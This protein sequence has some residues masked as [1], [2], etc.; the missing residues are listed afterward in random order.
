M[1]DGKKLFRQSSKY[2]LGQIVVMVA[3]FISFPVLT[4]IFTVDNYGTLGIVTT[5]IMLATAIAKVGSTNSS[6]RYFAEYKKNG[7]LQIYYSTMTF[8]YLSIAILVSLI[9]FVIGNMFNLYGNKN[10]ILILVISLLVILM[11]IYSVLQGMLRAEQKIKKYIVT[12]IIFRYGTITLG[13]LALFAIYKSIEIYLATQALVLLV[14]I[15]II[16]F[17]INKRYV[18]SPASFSIDLFKDSICYGFFL[19]ISE[20]AHLILTYADR[21]LIQYILGAA[22]LGVYTAGYNLST[23]VVE[24]LMY[25][26]NNAIDPIY[27]NIYSTRG[28]EDTQ[29]FLSKAFKYYFI[30]MAFAVLAFISVS[31][32]L[33]VILASSKYETA[34]KIMP[35]VVI[36]NAIYSL[37]VIINAGLI[38]NK[39]TS[40]LMKLKLLSCVINIMLNLILIPK[41][42]IVGAA[43]STLI[44]YLFYL[45]S[46]R[47]FSFKELSFEINGAV[48]IKY[49]VFALALFWLTGKITGE[50]YLLIAAIKSGIIFISFLA[51]IFLTEKDVRAAILALYQS[52]S[53]RGVKV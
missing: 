13:V 47:H 34:Y 22:A 4:R 38:I 11:S 35:Y 45:L 3:G 20:I 7:K 30:F 25:P 19:S 9:L 23:Y 33:I 37:Q 49:L 29:Q 2:F 51:L 1:T 44:S 36:A 24:V 39:K 12:N 14:I 27:L 5:T 32:E 50:S 41:Y 6:V 17:G 26:V 31:K 42:G 28:E 15:A 8:G 40:V 46:V 21:Y 10:I 18:I 43:Q 52:R 16:I 48:I 53:V